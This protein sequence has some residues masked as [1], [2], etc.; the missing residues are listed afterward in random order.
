MT[1]PRAVPGAVESRRDRERGLAPCRRP[2]SSGRPWRS[3]RL[4]GGRLGGR[5]TWSRRSWSSALAVALALVGRLGGALAGLAGASVVG[6]G[7]LARRR[8]RRAS[9]RAVL[10]SAAR[11]LPAAVWAPLALADL[12]AA[13][14]ALAA[15]AA[16]A[17]LVC[18]V[19]WPDVWTC[20]PPR[21][22]L[23]LRVRRDLRRAAAFGWMAPALAARSSARQR[24]GEGDGRILALDRL[25]GERQGLGDI[26][27]RGGAARDRGPRGVARPDGR[28]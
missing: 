21:A 26:G 20:A 8:P 4:G 11:A 27:L 28:A 5:S 14:R 2:S 13:M 22:A 16:A 24:L 15:L 1:T 23:T 3:R 7:G 6:R 25:G 12:P 18:L 10:L 17:L 9:A 19:T